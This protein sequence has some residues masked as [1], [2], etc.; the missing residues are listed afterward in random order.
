MALGFWVFMNY[1]RRV[2]FTPMR[3]A[4]W[5]KRHVAPKKM[6][7][8]ALAFEIVGEPGGNRTL[9]HMIKSHVLYR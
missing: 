6:R 5:R 9:D 4:G 8:Q 2:D 7:T 3:L 1:S